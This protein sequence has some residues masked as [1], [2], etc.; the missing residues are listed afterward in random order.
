MD[1]GYTTVNSTA[2][3]KEWKANAKGIDLNRNFPSGW[4]DSDRRASPSSEQYRGPKPF[5]AAESIALR[6]YT[7]KYDFDATISFHSSGN[8]IY[9]QYGDCQ[10]INRQSQSLAQSVERTTGYTLEE[11]DG[12]DGAGFKDWAIDEL[13]IPS[14][15]IEIGC[16]TSP[17]PERELYNVFARFQTIVPTVNAWIMR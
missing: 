15:T 2:Y 17:L 12:T 8:V 11:N 6:D 5:S 3:A 9:Y 10:P 16:T 1:A 14:I 13:G 4:D 7:L